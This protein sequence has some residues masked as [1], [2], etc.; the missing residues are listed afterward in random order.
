MGFY[1]LDQVRSIP[2][3]DVCESLGIQVEK[4]GNRSYFVKLRD[5][6]T[7]SCKLYLDGKDGY[8]S[9]CDFGNCKNGGDVIKFT[10][11]YLGCS[12]QEALDHLADRFGI[13]AIN[14]S[15]YMNRN[16]LTDIEWKKLGVHGDLATKNFDFDLEKYSL[17]SAQKFS[18]KYAMPVNQ[19]RKDFPNKY[20]Y[21]II[22]KRAIPFVYKMRNN[23]YFDL[24]CALSFQRDLTGHFD[25]NNVP[26]EDIDRLTVDCK[27]L[28]Q[29]ELLLR[30]ALR[31]TDVKYS[32]RDYDIRLD[33]QNIYLGKVS[34]EIG[35]TSYS[36]L[37]K[38]SSLQGV[39]LRY[40]SVSLGEYLSLK[41]YGIDM[42]SHAAFLKHDKVN[43]VFL[44]EH[45]ELIDKCIDLHKTAKVLDSVEQQVKINQAGASVRGEE[46]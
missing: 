45:S 32:F 8:D 12:W 25:I 4:H 31:G 20:V 37:K 3:L 15:E 5:E 14:N 34:F 21:E 2:I 24:Y 18:E 17:E 6:K 40:R 27:R 1:N 41:E 33:L 30:K 29:A 7:A 16:E 10:A 26:K 23:Y 46:R 19:L 28:A 38:E 35:E 39:D 13:P 9:F 43:L 44:P 36:D 11:E 42:V 22:K